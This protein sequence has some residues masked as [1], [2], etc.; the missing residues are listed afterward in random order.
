MKTAVEFLNSD[1]RFKY[2]Y[3]VCKR[4]DYHNFTSIKV[5][6]ITTSYNNIFFIP[7][8]LTYDIFKLMLNY[9]NDPTI[10]YELKEL[11]NNQLIDF[12]DNEL[13]DYNKKIFIKLLKLNQ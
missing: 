9:N 12:N 7:F 5:Q 4:D 10:T 2:N 11:N 8:N 3:Y 1:D 13:I 6:Y